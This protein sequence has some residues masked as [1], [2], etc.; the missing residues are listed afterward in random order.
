MPEV[1][2][3]SSNKRRISPTHEVYYSI[4]RYTKDSWEFATNA[5]N[6]AFVLLLTN[7]ASFSARS[8]LCTLCLCLLIECPQQLFRCSTWQHLE[9]VC[10]KDAL[11]RCHRHRDT[12]MTSHVIG[13]ERCRCRCGMIISGNFN[14]YAIF[15]LPW[16]RDCQS[17]RAIHMLSVATLRGTTPSAS[18]VAALPHTAQIGLVFYV[19]AL[20]VIYS[21]LHAR[22]RTC[23]TLPPA[24]RLCHARVWWCRR[25]CANGHLVVLCRSLSA[26]RSAEQDV[27]GTARVTL[28]SWTHPAAGALHPLQASLAKSCYKPRDRYTVPLVYCRI[29]WYS[30]YI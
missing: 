18:H 19:A 20:S 9:E 14:P 17:H 7:V 24:V 3:I 8:Q 6:S 25:R 11:S 2:S 28:M 26:T 13:G 10:T 4:P 22:K 29:S 15:S 1:E 16:L 27:A 5:H 12:P 23:N 30:R 21:I